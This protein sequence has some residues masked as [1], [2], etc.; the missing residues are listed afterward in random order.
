MKYNL[1]VM[2]IKNLLLSN[3]SYT[4]K[5]WEYSDVYV[6]F[7]RLYYIID[8]EAYYREG[9]DV[10]RFKKGHLYLTP[11]RK[12]FD[13]YENPD[14]KLLHTYSHIVTMPPVSE[15]TEIEVIPDTPLY[16]AVSLWRKY[17]R[18]EDSEL[19]ANIIALVLACIDRQSPESGRSA[20]RDGRVRG[21]Y[22]HRLL[23]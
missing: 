14:D 10:R 23:S 21:G 18:S 16:D 1:C 7:S 2:I 15:F 8:G 22:E 5:N 12:S 6:D 13:L 4:H 11:I 19:L 3:E 17:I 20:D 9:G